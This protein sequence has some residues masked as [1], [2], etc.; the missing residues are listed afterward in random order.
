MPENKTASEHSQNALL[1]IL[2]K[3]P[4]RESSGGDP[5]AG[6]CDDGGEGPGEIFVI[7]GNA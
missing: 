5:D 2:D 7:L 3:S 6:Q 1:H 4:P